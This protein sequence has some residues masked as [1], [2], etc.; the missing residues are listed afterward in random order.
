MPKSD[1]VHDTLYSRL[2]CFR[3][4]FVLLTG[5]NLAVRLPWFTFK[6]TKN[7][8]LHEKGNTVHIHTAGWNQF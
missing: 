7:G 3:R 1:L 4:D 2:P 5:H 6:P 8:A